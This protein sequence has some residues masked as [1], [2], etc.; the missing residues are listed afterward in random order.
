MHHSHAAITKAVIASAAEQRLREELAADQAGAVW[1]ELA[2]APL[3][4]CIERTASK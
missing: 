3:A 1:D 4:S 2:E